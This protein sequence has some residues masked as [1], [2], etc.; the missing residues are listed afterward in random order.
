[1]RISVGVVGLCLVLAGCQSFF[2]APAPVASADAATPGA[3]AQSH[4]AK[5]SAKPGAPAA[6]VPEAPAPSLI[7]PFETDAASVAAGIVVPPFPAGDPRQAAML[8]EKTEVDRL[9]ASGALTREGGAKRLYRL[10]AKNDL[11]KG[12]ADE[13]FWQ[14]LIQTYRNLDDHYITAEDAASDIN[15]AA[16]RR[17]VGK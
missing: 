17:L 3:E 8:S 1:M 9:V 6:P 5:A 11:V 15:A 2:S 16:A 10:A 14:T 12:K 13:G 4:P 7:L